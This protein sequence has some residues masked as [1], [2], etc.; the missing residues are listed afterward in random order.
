MKRHISEADHQKLTT[1]IGS[2]AILG[3]NEL[4]A[5]RKAVYGTAAPAR[6]KRDLLRY[7][8]AYRMQE[9]ALSGLKPSTRRLLERVADDAGARRPVKVTPA[10]KAQAGAV[11]L[12]KWGGVDHQVTVLENGVL[13]RGERHRSLSAVARVITGTR[14]SGPLFFGLKAQAREASANGAR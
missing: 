9:C 11:L 6:M 5:R 14:W 2:L 10:C 1:E 8:V 13:F 12:L 7:A 3:N 4:K